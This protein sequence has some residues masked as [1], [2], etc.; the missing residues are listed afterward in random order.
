[1]N[2]RPRRQYR[3]ARLNRV[4]LEGYLAC[5][6]T[7]HGGKRR[8]SF[9]M[10]VSK[11]W[12]DKETDE[13]KEWTDWFNVS[14]FGAAYNSLKKQGARKGD[15]IYLEGELHSRNFTEADGTKSNAVTIFVTQPP[16]ILTVRVKDDGAVE[17]DSFPEPGDPDYFDNADI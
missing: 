2:D 17:D 16:Q 14:C 3:L 10:A 12:R 6:P 9:R 7:P 11:R 15:G 1:M 5:D 8:V 13:W 4:Q